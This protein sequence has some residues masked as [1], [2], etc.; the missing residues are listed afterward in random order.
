M[1]PHEFGKRAEFFAEKEFLKRHTSAEVIARNWRCKAGELDR[2]FRV[3]DV[4]VVLEV[5]ARGAS[6]RMDPLESITPKKRRA[7]RKGIEFFLLSKLL[8]ERQREGL[9]IQELRV[10][11]ASIRFCNGR[12]ELEF[13]QGVDCSS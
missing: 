2:V 12:V 6:S 8:R 5:R 13:I 1:I 3:G 7:L 9:T 4:L 10:D 11:V